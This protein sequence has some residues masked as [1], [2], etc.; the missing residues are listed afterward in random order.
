MTNSSN[1]PQQAEG[2]YLQETRFFFHLLCAK[3]G[4]IVFLETFGDV[5]TIR[6]DGSVISEEDKSTVVNNPITDRSINLWKT[7]YNWM[8][9]IAEGR[10]EA[11]KTLFVIYVPSTKFTG[12]FINAFHAAADLGDARKAID[13]VKSELLGESPDSRPKMSVSKSISKYVYY[14]FDNEELA[15]KII[16]NFT[17]ETGG[18]AGYEEID[19]KIKDSPVPDEYHEVYRIHMLGWIKERIDMLISKNL[20]AQISRDEFNNERKIY[21]RKLNKEEILR[22]VSTRPN[23]TKINDQIAKETNVYTSA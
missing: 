23:K 13:L 9:S 6:S 20:P 10:L 2:F 3:S 11:N 7:F 12:K 17:F 18:F 19:S 8:F 22:S 16:S 14:F 21:L 5:A 4:D 15:A 1:V